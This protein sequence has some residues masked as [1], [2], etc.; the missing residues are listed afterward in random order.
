MSD[1]SLDRWRGSDQTSEPHYRVT[2]SLQGSEAHS[3]AEREGFLYIPGG[4]EGRDVY[5]ATPNT[6]LTLS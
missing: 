2:F 5:R 6:P 1:P 3:W 4:E